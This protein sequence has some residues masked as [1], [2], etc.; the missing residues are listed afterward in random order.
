[1]STKLWKRARRVARAAAADVVKRAEA[2]RCCPRWR[3]MVA[4]LGWYGPARRWAERWQKMSDRA[5]VRAIKRT[6]HHLVGG[7]RARPR[8]RYRM[9]KG[10]PSAPPTT[11]PGY[12]R[13]IEP[14][15][16]WPRPPA[17]NI[18]PGELNGPAPKD[19]TLR[20]RAG[21]D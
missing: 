3:Q 19:D 4:A 15:K 11:R 2:A 5:K 21:I 7:R 17:K 13:G 6:T 1:M 16:P 8:R 20:E 18:T 12:V 14:D 9:R 10:A